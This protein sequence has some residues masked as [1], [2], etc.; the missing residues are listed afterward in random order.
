MTSPWANTHKPTITTRTIQIQ[1]VTHTPRSHLS[2]GNE[3]TDKVACKVG[4]RQ[5]LNVKSKSNLKCHLDITYHMATSHS[6]QAIK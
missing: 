6:R 2:L 3:Y 1:Q 4:S 5:V